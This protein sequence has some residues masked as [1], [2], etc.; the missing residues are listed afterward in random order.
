MIKVGIFFGGAS[1]EREVSFAGG[2]TVYDNLDKGI[3]DPVP[4]FVDAKGNFVELK[5]EFVYRGTI[6]DFFPPS[7]Y[8]PDSDHHFQIYSES[9]D[10]DDMAYNKMLNEIGNPLSIEQLS[11]KIDFAFLALHGSFGEDGTL[12]GML[13]WYNIP[14]SG[15]G[16][17]PSALGVSK[18]IQKK[19]W[20]QRLP[21]QNYESIDLNEWEQSDAQQLFEEL[22]EKLGLPFVAKSSNQGSSIGVQVIENADE[23]SKKVYS[24]FFIR[25]LSKKDWESIDQVQ[26]VRE[27]TDLRI[28]LG[29]PIL[30]DN[31][32]CLHPEDLLQTLKDGFEHKEKIRLQATAGEYEV[33]FESF[34]K[35]REF[36]C[37][38][39][40]DDEGKALA[41]PPTE[42][43]KGSEIFDYNSKYLPG[44]SH[45]QTPINIE[46]EKIEEIRKACVD[47]FD[48]FEFEV[49]AR[50]D[51]FITAD[52][53]FLN[54]P[55][56]TSGMMPSSFFFHQAA[57]IGL[58]PKQ[59]VTYIIRTSLNQ[60]LRKK[61][62]A[63]KYKALVSKID[64]HLEQGDLALQDKTKV[65]V[66]LGGYSTER[67][68]SVESGR[69]I[70][71]KLSSSTKYLPQPVFLSGKD[72]AHRLFELPVNIML[73]DNADDIRDKVENPKPSSILQKIRL[74]AKKVTSKYAAENHRFEPRE[75][76]YD[77]LASEYDEVFIALHGRP[78]EDGQVQ[79][80]LDR[81]GVPY[82]GSGV[83]SSQLTIDKY[84]SNQI[85]RENGVRVA[86]HQLISKTQWMNDRDSLIQQI[87]LLKYP[88]IAKPHDEGCSS[89]VIKIE[90]RSM[91]ETY[92]D[93]CFGQIERS[94]EVEEVL[95]IG[96]KDEFPSK[97]AFMVEDFTSK[98]DADRFLEITGGMLT[99]R[100]GNEL[101]Y[102]VFEASEA[103]SSGKVLSLAEKF[104]AG[105]GQNITP[106]RY[107]KNTEEQKRIS[108]AVKKEFE[109]VARLLQVEGY[110]R[111]DAFVRIYEGKEPDVIIIEV[112]SLPG[113]TPA[114]CIYH[115]AAINN[116]KPYEFIDQILEYGKSRTSPVV[117]RA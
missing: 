93:L 13:E 65:A 85:L 96:S 45:K 99:Y 27:T 87:E 79:A 89:A 18:Q 20:P 14:Y 63:V 43:V 95:Q 74:E 44:L 76:K 84:Q 114:T 11:K 78:G 4:I 2:R 19:W 10:L 16:I 117:N 91:L 107:S 39:I 36:S 90:D 47:L 68:I 3:F 75:I 112:N 80:H 113:M 7:A 116:Y 41:L 73:K 29:V 67:H 105:E 104:L 50:I 22:K 66:I 97:D 32:L 5:W 111:I 1:R 23:F 109:K 83:A 77:D 88:L 115:Q 28:G 103:L 8:L 53:I 110:C 31:D 102:E 81:L 60:R 108:A 64:A 34:L 56:T 69:N 48:Y 54:D 52:G 94:P 33:I 101:K 25:D 6:R 17:L 15:S 42:V 92:A 62:S 9:L 70:Y 37:I 58:S 30:V 71:E 59:F 46:D 61:P 35:G 100:E 86:D 49:Y 106:A 82:N 12:Q 24:T 72:G 38:V 98:K 51:G 55:N 26:F 21:I 40:Q 57:E